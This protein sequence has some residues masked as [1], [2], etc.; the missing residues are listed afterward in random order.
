MIFTS[1]LIQENS[2]VHLSQLS[3]Y[4]I[5]AISGNISVKINWL[6]LPYVV[7]HYVA[8]YLMLNIKPI[9]AYSITITHK[10]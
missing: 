10:V 8:N 4:V 1:S 6:I 9:T 5:T 2:N 3:L 7:I